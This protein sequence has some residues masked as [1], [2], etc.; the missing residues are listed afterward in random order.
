MDVSVLISDD[1]GYRLEQGSMLAG[2][3]FVGSEE[4]TFH[5]SVSDV[6]EDDFR[7]KKGSFFIFYGHV[8]NLPKGGEQVGSRYSED[9]SKFLPQ[10]VLFLPL[11]SSSLIKVF[12]THKKP[13]IFTVRVNETGRIGVFPLGERSKTRRL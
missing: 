13:S 10:R 9:G 2:R 4:L 3:F 8:K 12:F 5:S 11:S 6:S 7:D 1:E